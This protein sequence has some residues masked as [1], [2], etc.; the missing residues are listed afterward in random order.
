MSDET[1]PTQKVMKPL[2]GVTKDRREAT[3]QPS[4]FHTQLN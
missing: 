1:T 4:N 2:T 3:T